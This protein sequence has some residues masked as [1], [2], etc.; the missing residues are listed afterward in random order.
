[1][2]SS[3]LAIS[4][5]HFPPTMPP[6]QIILLNQLRSEM[7]KSDINYLEVQYIPLEDRFLDFNMCT[8]CLR[9]VKKQIRIQ[10]D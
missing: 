8:N 10:Y 9:P 4:P 7:T 2:P 3:S 6:F 1:M 5:L